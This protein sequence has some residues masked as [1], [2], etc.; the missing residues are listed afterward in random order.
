MRVFARSLASLLCGAVIYLSAAPGAAQGTTGTVA[1]VVIDQRTA[2]PVTGAT[3]TLNHG[4]SVV[5]TTMTDVN[6]SYMFS[7][8]PP[9]I[10]SVGIQA[11]GY[12]GARIDD[13][14]VTTGAGT[15]IRTP[16]LAANTTTTGQNLEVIGSTHTTGLSGNT[17]A[18]SS[19]I[20]TN[21]DPAQMQQ[22]GFFNAAE[23]L[24][25]VPGVNL[26]GSPHSVG[27]DIS[28]DI[29]GM[30]PGEVRPLVD[31]HPIGPLGIGNQDYFDYTNSAF[32]LLQNIQV[33]EGSGATGLYGVD[34]IGGTIDF[35]TLNPTAAP[36]YHFSQAYGDDGTLDTL[37]SAT[38]TDGKIG[39]ALG[40]S[41]TGTYGN[42]EP[43]QI[44][45]SGR[46]NNNS[47]LPGGGACTASN[48]VSSCNQALNTYAV[49]GNYKTLNDLVKL[50]Y[51]FTPSTTL[52]I[53]GYST[54][55]YED[56][57]GNGDDDNIPYGTRLAQIQ[58]TPGGG[59]GCA[60][61]LYPVVTNAGPACY[62]AQQWA[63]ASSGPF[64]GGSGR[65]R[66]TTLQDYSATFNTQLGNNAI[67]INTY[68][69]YYNFH[70]YSSAAAGYNA[71]GT[72]LIGGG[73]YTDDYLSHG[74]LISD[75]IVSSANDVGFGYFVEHQKDYGDNIAAT[76][77]AN[78][79]PVS[80]YFVP[81][82]TYGEGDYSFFLRDIYTPRSDLSFFLN[83][84][85]RRSSVT[86][87]TSVDPRVSVVYKPTPH[88]VVRLTAGEA[89]GDPSVDLTQADALSGISNASSLNP[90]CAG[91]SSI[92]TSGNP[93]LLP[94]RSKDLEAAYGHR[95]WGDTAINV[96][97][98]VST[99]SNQIFTSV[100]PITAQA[101][102]N[103]AIAPYLGNFA[104]KID[105]CPGDTGR[106][107]AADVASALGLSAPANAATALYRGVEASGRIRISRQFRLDFTYNVQS[108]QQ[109]GIPNQDLVNT[110]YLLDG[111]QVEGIPLQQATATIDYT[112]QGFE[113]QFQGYYVG[114]NNTWN[115][116]AFTYFNGFVSKKVTPRVTLTF[117]S[118]NVFNQ[119]PQLYGYFGAG[120][121]HET[122]QYNPSA[123]T[124]L[125][126]AVIYGNQS[127]IEEMGLQPR[128]VKLQFDYA[129]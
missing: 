64:G 3:V 91:L 2:L 43:Q 15:T 24:G 14:A 73:T 101:L 8:E 59:N 36:H 103:P 68:S 115:R 75:D 26:S 57:T 67:A 86:Q 87:H 9:G 55:T 58:G 47:N 124:Q 80:L 31:G 112:H 122:N 19:T 71:A 42:F 74:L 83:A 5:A 18:A 25:Q 1:G 63:A 65:D 66:G 13:V 52:T 33:T 93:N 61:N 7:S 49:S 11:R 118:F 84:W 96:D 54:N 60:S 120:L 62:T 72:E 111:G 107:T 41:V 85:D 70:K 123:P 88:D 119:I 114:N 4:A 32:S 128:T 56:S 98:Y 102:A 20:Q 69:D 92:A 82:A 22:L 28:I 39:Y 30:G 105:T 94:E 100:I 48:D 81:Q 37:F 113:T 35:Q 117:S 38:G 121:A 17:L 126:Q 129:I 97:A 29:R 90:N 46:P 16:L 21:L 95:F 89:D 125:Q 116:P 109:F 99:V 12:T 45:Q 44:F 79:N 127:W 6:G 108:A 34:V 51:S 50:R 40:H 53:T 27:D 78:G 10:Y 104:T 77:D 76:T 110:P 23:A 106:Y